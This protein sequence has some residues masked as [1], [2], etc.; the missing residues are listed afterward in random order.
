VPIEP[1][2]PELTIDMVLYAGVRFAIDPVL[3]MYNGSQDHGC[4]VV[5]MWMSEPEPEA[6]TDMFCMLTTSQ[7]DV[8]T[9]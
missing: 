7:P 6:I 9:P 2:T 3:M 8:L 5:T 1:D 4:T